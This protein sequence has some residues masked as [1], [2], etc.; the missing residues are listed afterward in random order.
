MNRAA[1]CTTKCATRQ[2]G[3]CDSEPAFEFK[4]YALWFCQRAWYAV[5]H[6]GGRGEIRRLKLSRFTAGRV[7]DRPFAM[8]D[9]FDPRADLGLAWR[10]IRGD[11]PHAV[12]VRFEPDFS[13]NA[14]ETKWHSTQGTPLL[15]PRHR[16]QL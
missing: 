14:S 15:L 1:M 13:D 11:A 10:M 9:N 7:T 8:P 2:D 16:P 5:G 4:P 6:H 12:A 3:G